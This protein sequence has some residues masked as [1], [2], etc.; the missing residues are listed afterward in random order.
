M[1]TLEIVPVWFCRPERTIGEV[2]AWLGLSWILPV[3]VIV[4]PTVKVKADG[5]L[6]LFSFKMD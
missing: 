2:P 3:P 4:L 6:V 5:V 1:P